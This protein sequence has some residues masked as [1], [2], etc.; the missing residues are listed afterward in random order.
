[1]KKSWRILL[2]VLLAALALAACGGPNYNL[3]GAWRNEANNVT[4]IFQQNGHLLIQQQGAVQN[5]L[6]EFT[7][8]PGV[9]KLKAFEG[10]PAEQTADMSFTISGDQL[11][12]VEQSAAAGATQQGQPQIFTRVK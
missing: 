11:S 6:Y 3:Y 10:A 8:S 9:I 7:T 1:M 12:L 5:M 4:L 2:I